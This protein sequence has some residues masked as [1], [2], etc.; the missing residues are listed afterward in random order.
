MNIL[1]N[2]FV[3]P[4]GLE[5]PVQLRSGFTVRAATSY[6]LRPQ[7]NAFGGIEPPYPITPLA[8]VSD[9]KNR[10]VNHQELT[11]KQLLPNIQL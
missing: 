7:D 5:P 2:C 10:S 11:K 9:P 3:G 4:G 6:R 1:E 8:L